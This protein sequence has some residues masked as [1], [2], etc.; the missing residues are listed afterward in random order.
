MKK[1]F[2]KIKNLKNTNKKLYYAIICLFVLT[3]F[4]FAYVIDQISG[5]A[6]SR[7]F[8][9]A[10]TSD[11]FELKVDH[12]IIEIKPGQFNFGKGEEDLTG[13]ATATA[14]LKAN[15]T[16]N[17]ALYE[18]NIYF[19]IE[20]NE[21][22]YTTEDKKPEMILQVTDPTG[23]TVTSVNG[24]TYDSLIQGFDITETDGIIPIVENYEITSNSSTTF[25]EQNWIIKV[26][27][28]NLDSN[29]I[30]NEGKTL[31][32]KILIQTEKLYDDVVLSVN[33]L[34]TNIGHLTTLNCSGTTGM[35]NQKYDRFEFSDIF[36]NSALC[37]INYQERA[38]K[39]YLNE[40]IINL[41]KTNP[42]QGMGKI[43]HE[44]DKVINYEN[45]VS[46]NQSE[47]GTVEKFVAT[48]TTATTGT[49]RDDIFNFENL[50]WINN[51]SVMEASK[52]YN[53]KLTIPEDGYYQLCYDISGDGDSDN[54]IMFYHGT[55]STYYNSGLEDKIN[56][57]CRHLGLLKQNEVY[58]FLHRTGQ[59][60]STIKFSLQ[61][62]NSFDTIDTG[63][64]YEG[65]SPN[66]YLWF[67]NELWRIV[68]VFDDKIHGVENSN[69]VK[70]VKEYTIG[71]FPWSTSHN[72]E[73]SASNL[74]HIL[75]DF[76]L[77][78]K[79]GNGSEYCDEVHNCD[80]EYI[81][82]S[83]SY[84]KMIQNSK[85][86]LSEISAKDDGDNNSY[87]SPAYNYFS[88]ERNAKYSTNL[89]GMIY[90]SD[91]GYSVLSNSCER[92]TKLSSYGNN[93]CA[94][95]SWLY[96]GG[97]EWIFNI[98]TYNNYSY[99]IYTQGSTQSINATS[100]NVG[101]NYNVRPSLYLKSSVYVVDG[102]GSII[103]P[104][105]I[106]M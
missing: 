102:D 62:T 41:E 7:V 58:R 47:Y 16:N 11:V 57:G 60:I 92:T 30:D 50:E 48:S 45:S 87:A 10:D 13:T 39:Q 105:I 68:G 15:S 17:N 46:L 49:I 25:T 36:K 88:F 77:R 29:Q 104:Y 75:N 95:S 32:G 18:Y 40:Y 28:V 98:S 73:W 4:T 83:Y 90:A 101:S 20:K 67:N 26:S 64:R 43:V 78:K 74:N 21:Y 33:S 84:R 70:L 94:G 5:G 59:K 23:A 89:I 3:G 38:D 79:N 82:I 72:N 6:I 96:A 37:E 53:L 71:N 61:K 12:E 65:K 19:Y 9:T 14:R 69:L 42:N 100:G 63:Y 24:L 80:F 2:E 106:G 34:P 97:D 86:F 93:N 103:N 8:I 55:Q 66:N 1:Y 76:Y 35:Y 99:Y 91:Y 22:I 52:I 51:P 27:F 85:W 54:T 56:K 81:G 31:E 44:I